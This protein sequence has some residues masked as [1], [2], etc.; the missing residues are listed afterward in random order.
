MEAFRKLYPGEY[1]ARYQRRGVRPDGRACDEVRHTRIVCG[2]LRGPVGS[3]LVR[4]G[5]TAVIASASPRLALAASSESSGNTYQAMDSSSDDTPTSTAAP[6]ILALNVELLPV[7]GPSHR[8]GRPSAQAQSLCRR[9]HSV[10]SSSALPSELLPTVRIL[11]S[12]EQDA[13]QA[14]PACCPPL[15]W[16]FC[17]DVYALED[18]GGLF[19]ACL[20]AAVSALQQLR[21]PA[22]CLASS[23]EE[24]QNAP[25]L[26]MPTVHPFALCEPLSLRADRL[27]ASLSFGVLDGQLLADPT[28]HEDELLS[29]SLHVVLAGDGQLLLTLQPGGESISPV[30]LA[31]AIKQAR[32]HCEHLFSML[33]QQATTA[34]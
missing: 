24:A 33:D 15:Q 18:A 3:A 4:R 17:V 10:L 23:S 28:H 2:V 14:D 7:C 9:L 16:R 30:L 8:P 19:D 6:T 20:L 21:L 1:Q 31:T 5:R 27:P 26:T 34:S 12:A 22:L 25:V 29:A 11:S 13:E 32:Q